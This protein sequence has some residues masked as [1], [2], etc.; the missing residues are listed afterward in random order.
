MVRTIVGNELLTHFVRLNTKECVCF[1][2]YVLLLTEPQASAQHSTV[3][4]GR[5]KDRIVERLHYCSDSALSGHVPSS[6]S[7]ILQH[8]NKF[9]E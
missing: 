7:P 4:L 8:H 3:F 9:R 5:A 6:E 1:W 2:H